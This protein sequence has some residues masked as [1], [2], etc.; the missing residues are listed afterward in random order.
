[1]KFLTE[2]F[3]RFSLKSPAFFQ[4]IQWLSIAAAAIA[5]IPAMISQ[6]E[7][8][9]GL[10]VPVW[11]TD[12]SNK[13]VVIASVVAWIIAKL[14]VKTTETFKVTTVRKLPFTEQK[15]EIN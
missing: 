4:V 6:F 10:H 2:F 7:S 1:M 15:Q 8:D 14:P 9:L 11:M 3:N 13:A 5:G 12:F